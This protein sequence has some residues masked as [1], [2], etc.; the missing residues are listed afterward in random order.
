[1]PEIGKR[2]TMPK[3]KFSY[4]LK[5]EALDQETIIRQRPWIEDYVRESLGKEFSKTKLTWNLMRNGN[6]KFRLDFIV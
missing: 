6:F 2:Y 4:V 3:S 5:G 1:M